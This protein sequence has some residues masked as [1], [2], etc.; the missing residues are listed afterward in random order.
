VAEIASPQS[1]A[2][3]RPLLVGSTYRADLV[4]VGLRGKTLALYMELN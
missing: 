1:A 3:L 4:A 2:Q